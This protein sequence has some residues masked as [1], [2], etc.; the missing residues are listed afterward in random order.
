MTVREHLRTSFDRSIP[1]ERRHESSAIVVFQRFT[2]EVG[3][4]NDG[5]TTLYRKPGPSSL[6][7]DRVENRIHVADIT[8]DGITTEMGSITCR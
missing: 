1:L 5:R 6:Y 7:P 8:A 4:H 2:P 3:E